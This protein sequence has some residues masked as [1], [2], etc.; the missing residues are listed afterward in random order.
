MQKILTLIQKNDNTYDIDISEEYKEMLEGYK[1]RI[2]QTAM[3]YIETVKEL[4]NEPLI[5]EKIE[6]LVNSTYTDILKENNLLIENIKKEVI[7]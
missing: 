2:L 6:D 5:L 7:N 4:K 1:D 3:T